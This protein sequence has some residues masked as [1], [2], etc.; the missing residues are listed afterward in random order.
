M[1]FISPVRRPFPFI[2][3]IISTKNPTLDSASNFNFNQSSAR[4]GASI[5][6]KTCDAYR[7]DLIRTD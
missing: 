5:A 1:P 3:D 2:H 7:M 6:N 4:A